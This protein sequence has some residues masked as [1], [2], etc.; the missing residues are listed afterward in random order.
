MNLLQAFAAE[1]REEA[2]VTRKILAVVPFEHAEWKPHAKSMTLKR[3]AVHVAELN[4]W[5]R[6]TLLQDVLD[7][8]TAKYEPPKAENNDDLL[9][10]FDKHFVDAEQ[11][12]ENANESVLGESWTMRAGEQVYFTK[13]KAH[14]LRSFVFNHLVHHRAQL[15]V[16][17]RQLEVKLPG[18]YGPTADDAF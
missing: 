17:L 5:V 9:A 11:I 2:E 18:S 1:L 6:I 12:L 4:S 16:Y 13:C 3:L 14:V 15:G 8:A 7:F 10:L